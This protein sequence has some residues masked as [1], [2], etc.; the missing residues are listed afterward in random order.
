MW[1]LF[2]I[3]VVNRTNAT[4]AI[5]NRRLKSSPSFVLSVIPS[6][7]IYQQVAGRSNV[8]GSLCFILMTI[9]DHY[10]VVVFISFYFKTNLL[11]FYLRW[12]PII[13]GIYDLATLL[14]FTLPLLESYKDLI[15]TLFFFFDLIVIYTF[16]LFFFFVLQNKLKFFAR[17]FF[18]KTPG[19]TK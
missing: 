1:R 7:Q 9:E 18:I 16:L 13:F 19:N 15:Y 3:F 11:L 17:W 14:I 12:Y 5:V 10:T 8:A 2:H 4:F 6:T